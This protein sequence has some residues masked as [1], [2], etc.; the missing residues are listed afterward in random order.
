MNTVDLI[1]FQTNKEVKIGQKVVCVNS[2]H[3][4]RLVNG[5][6]YI[7]A[8]LRS[9]NNPLTTEYIQLEGY[10]AEGFYIWRFAE[11]ETVK[12]AKSTKNFLR[13]QSGRF[14]PK[15]NLAK[16]VILRNGSLYGVQRRNGRVIARLRKVAH[17]DYLV[18]SLRG[19]AFLAR[20]KQVTL[21][22]KDEV[23]EY[24]KASK[25]EKA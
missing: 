10:G 23:D 15:T 19:K 9:R 8:G 25:A 11:A 4:S 1:A 21:A 6:I 18:F 5:Q 2:A 16:P 24:L 20:K 7:V 3:N 13:D 12:Q 17:E 14:A 22:T